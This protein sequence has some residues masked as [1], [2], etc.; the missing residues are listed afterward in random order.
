VFLPLFVHKNHFSRLGTEDDLALVIKNGLD[1]LVTDLKKVL[2]AE[3]NRIFRFKIFL[4]VKLVFL[5]YLFF[6]FA[7][8][9]R[10]EVAQQLDL[11]FEPLWVVI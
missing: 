1:D 5:S 6:V 9:H 8:Q 3:Q 10:L 4:N 11:L 2:E 7:Y